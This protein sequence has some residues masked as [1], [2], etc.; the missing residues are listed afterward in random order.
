MLLSPN[1]ASVYHMCRQKLKGVEVMVVSL[2]V[3]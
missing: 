2:M 3:V 1:V